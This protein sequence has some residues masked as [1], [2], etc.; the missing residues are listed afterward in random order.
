MDR[1]KG[2]VLSP[3]SSISDS[4]SFSFVRSCDHC[5]TADRSE[6]N[7]ARWMSSQEGASERYSTLNMLSA[8]KSMHVMR[9]KGNCIRRQTWKELSVCCEQSKNEQHKK[10]NEKSRIWLLVYKPILQ[11]IHQGP[12]FYYI[13]QAMKE[14][15]V[16]YQGSHSFERSSASSWVWRYF[17]SRR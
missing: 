9:T 8:T 13:H 4:L 1:L 12:A 5:E 14:L 7:R 17:S 2:F 3:V 10:A 6:S 16:N 11:L 15:W